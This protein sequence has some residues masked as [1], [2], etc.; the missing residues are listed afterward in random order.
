MNIPALCVSRPV[1]TAMLTLIAVVVG[2]FSMFKLPIDLLP[3]LEIPTVSVRAEY[4]NASPE[5]MERL[6]TEYIEESVSVV[7]GVDELTSTSGEGSTRVSARFVWGTDIDEAANDVRTRIDRVIDELPD[8]LPRPRVS[9][10]DPN[11]FPIVILG[12]ASPLD[13]VELTEMVEDELLYR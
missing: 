11:S 2:L 9:K 8:D 7:A 6:V 5:E 4:G 1:A 13:P 3:E 12:I 10:F